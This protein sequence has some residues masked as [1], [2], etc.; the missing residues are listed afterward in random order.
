METITLEQ[1]IKVVCIKAKSFPEGIMNAHENLA[2]LIPNIHERRKF[3]LSRPENGKI[4]YKA[5]TEELFPGEAKE[6]KSERLV[7]RKGKYNCIM[8]RDYQKDFPAIGIAFQKLLHIPGIDQQGY[9]VEWYA[10]EN[11]VKCMVRMNG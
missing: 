2:V 4:E 7:I 11:D 3:G 6:L 9:C 8:I 5:A 1:D 10:N